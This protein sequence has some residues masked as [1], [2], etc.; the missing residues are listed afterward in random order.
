IEILGSGPLSKSCRKELDNADR[1][2]VPTL[3]LFEVYRKIL[4]AVSEDQALA[5]VA[6]MSQHDV[7][8][9]SRD[10]A[11]TAGDLSVQ[12]KLGMAD[13]MVLAHSH[14]ASATLITL[15]NDFSG[16]PGVKILRKA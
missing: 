7:I 15:D 6:V 12:L 14:A 4:T 10:V 1:V 2:V 3:V 11:L 5:A 13:S 16:V 8:D 9:L